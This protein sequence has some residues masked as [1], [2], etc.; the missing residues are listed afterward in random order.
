M[1]QENSDINLV[2]RN[3]TLYMQLHLW[4][5]KAQDVATRRWR[6][7]RLGKE[8]LL[9]IR[10]TPI[11]RKAEMSLPANLRVVNRFK[12]SG[13]DALFLDSFLSSS[14]SCETLQW[15]QWLVNVKG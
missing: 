13:D 9:R 5:A 3:L 1:G 4:R 12:V 14:A 15:R 8:R 10:N 7:R 11:I 6:R 2:S